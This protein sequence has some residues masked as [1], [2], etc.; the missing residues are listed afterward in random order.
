MD[1][2]VDGIRSQSKYCSVA[3]WSDCTPSIPVIPMYFKEGA[4]PKCV[5]FRLKDMGIF[6]IGSVHLVLGPYMSIQEPFMVFELSGYHGIGWYCPCRSLKIS[7]PGQLNLKRRVPF[8]IM[9][10]LTTY[11]F[12]K[13]KKDLSPV[14]SS[15]TTT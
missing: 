10:L 6:S 2:V 3:V 13:K 5:Y 15:L 4:S 12:K 9:K 8:L 14:L 1:L 7:G 11:L